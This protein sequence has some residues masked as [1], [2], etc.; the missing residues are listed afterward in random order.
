MALYAFDGTWNK[1]RPGTERDTNV[2]RFADAYLPA[3]AVHYVPGVGTR[4]GA[5]GKIVGGI[6]GAGARSRVEKALDVLARNFK[7]GDTAIDI[8][9]FSRG[10]AIAIEFAY[11]IDRDGVA[12]QASPPIRFLGLWDCV[13][14]FGIPGNTFDLG[15]HVSNL[16]DNVGK[17]YHALSLDE[18]RGTFPLNRLSARVANADQEGRLFEV[19][20]R[21]VHSD[22]GGGNRNTGLSDIALAWMFASARRTGLT[23]D[24]A[25]VARATSGSD[26]SAAISVHDLDPV[27]QPFRVVR[28]NDTVHASVTMRADD[29]K[30]KHNN[31]P[32]GVARVDDTGTILDQRLA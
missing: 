22:V 11:R 18:R 10:A 13:P 24:P 27:P 20:F 1:D 29:K 8:V 19:W 30:R 16:P 17:C 5:L 23:L 14:S 7:A 6:A 28:W 2:R 32:M 31:P 25:A 4:F 15:W 12:G 9:G 3:T 21:G 26:P